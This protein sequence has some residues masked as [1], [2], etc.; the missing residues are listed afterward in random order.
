VTTVTDKGFLCA[1]LAVST[2]KVFVESSLKPRAAGRRPSTCEP[3]NHLRVTLALQ[4]SLGP[5]TLI[6]RRAGWSVDRK[7][8][9]VKGRGQGPVPAALLRG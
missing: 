6:A 4:E 8:D 1:H 2:N 3:P 9:G 7:N 5:G